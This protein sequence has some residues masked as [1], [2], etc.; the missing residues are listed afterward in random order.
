MIKKIFLASLLLVLMSLS[1]FAFSNGDF[2][3]WNTE[4]ID[5]KVNKKWTAKVEQE[6]RFGDNVS[7]LYYTHTDAGFNYKVMDWLY[8]GGN[9]RHVVFKNKKK[10]VQEYRPHLNL[11]LKGKW[12]VFKFSNRNRLEYRIYGFHKKDEVRYRNKTTVGYP[13]EWEGLKAEPYVADEIFVSFTKAKFTRN[14]LYAGLKFD[15]V[16][17]LKSDIFYL[18]QISR[19]KDKW[20]GINVLGLKLKMVF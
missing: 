7:E 5:W 15:I 16:K 4:S 20:P 18:W 17:H 12:E 9:Y 11:T 2:Q 8:F 10:W 14:R 1:A 19:K 13:F 3:I 6:L